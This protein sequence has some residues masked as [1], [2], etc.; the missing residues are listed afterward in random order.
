MSA[1]GQRRFVGQPRDWP[2]EYC[3]SVT[4]G[5]AVVMLL[6]IAGG[7][8]IT[9]TSVHW[10]QLRGRPPSGI[11]TPATAVANLRPTELE[12]PK[13]VVLRIT[14]DDPVVRLNDAVSYAK[15]LRFMAPSP[16]QYEV[17]VEGW[18][19]PCPVTAILWGV[20][21]LPVFV[22][23]VTL[24]DS[25]GDQMPTI[26]GRVWQQDPVWR[27]QPIKGAWQWQVGESG[28][29]YLLITSEPHGPTVV[30]YTNNFTS[31]TASPIGKIRV[32]LTKKP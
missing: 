24:L 4:H 32:A 23:Q 9:S 6:M 26:E 10:E 2:G 29:Y 11:L 16:G 3:A 27:S 8:S 25:R 20:D 28:P 5:L 22:P 7:C 15:L 30:G 21:E 19:D 18:C 31:Y 12:M 14:H 13:R 17:V 1:I